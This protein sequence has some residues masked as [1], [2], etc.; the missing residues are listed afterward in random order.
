MDAFDGHLNFYRFVVEGDLILCELIVDGPEGHA[1]EEGFL[2][3]EAI[4]GF[5]PFHFI[6]QWFVHIIS[7]FS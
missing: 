7:I 1:F 5:N 6:T 4:R 3:V 2:R